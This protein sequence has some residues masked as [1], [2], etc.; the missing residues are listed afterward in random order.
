MEVVSV[1]APEPEPRSLGAAANAHGDGHDD[2][3]GPH[4]SGKLILIPIVILAFFAVTALVPLLL[5]GSCEKLMG[6]VMV[7]DALSLSLAAGSAPG[8]LTSALT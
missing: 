4:E 7:T 6:S 1:G 5:L 2:H 8:A 3:G